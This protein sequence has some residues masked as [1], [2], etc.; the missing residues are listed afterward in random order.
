[1]H[2]DGGARKS[3]SYIIATIIVALSAP[4]IF[5]S[6]SGPEGTVLGK[7]TSPNR[8][9]DA[10]LVARKAGATVPTPIELY[11]VPHGQD[12]KRETA[13]LRGDKFEGLTMAWSQQRLLEIRYRKGRIFK[14]TNFWNSAE[15]QQFQFTVELRLVPEAPWTIP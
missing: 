2:R 6:C 11:L 3:L 8:L 14:F 9:V 15:I 1:M 13:V 4:A 12:W 10:F 7:A 5:I